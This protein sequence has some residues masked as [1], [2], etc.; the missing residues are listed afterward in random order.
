M[1]KSALLAATAMT[2]SLAACA[3]T[4]EPTVVTETVTAAAA[5]DTATEEVVAVT[6]E[7]VAPTSEEPEPTT[8]EPT[9][10][11]A[12]ATEADSADGE[13]NFGDPE[14]S[15]RGNLVKEIGQAAGIGDPNGETTVAFT[16]TDVTADFECTTDPMM[17]DPPANRHYVAFEWDVETG[18]TEAM[19]EAFYD[20]LFTLSEWD[21]S[22]LD[23]NGK[24]LNDVSGN[25]LWC[26]ESADSL[27]TE[28]GPK[29][30]ASGLI[31]LDLEVTSGILV[32]SGSSWGV[33]GG[34]EWAF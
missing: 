3:S 25:A 31:V 32:I 13:P 26:L 18:S 28:I 23:A 4:P 6:S 14:T 22:V 24:R 8:E 5:T 17:A 19:T 16:L 9:E 12:E 11:E 30:T 21:M 27:P 1:T 29:Q 2:L 33:D 34:W 7:A 20:P 15:E 10:S